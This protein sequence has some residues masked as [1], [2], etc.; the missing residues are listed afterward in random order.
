MLSPHI[1]KALEGLGKYRESAANTKAHGPA[2][3]VN[4]LTGKAGAF[5]EKLRYLIDYKEEHTI[6]RN[7]IERILRRNLSFEGRVEVGLPLLQEMVSGSYLPN[8]IISESVAENIQAIVNKYILLERESGVGRSRIVSLMACEI[9]HFLYPQLIHE[10]IVE[11]FYQTIHKHVTYTDTIEPEKLQAQTYIGCRRSLLEDDNETL[12]YALVFKRLPELHSMSDDI[13]AIRAIAPRFAQA[14]KLIEEEIQDPLGWRLSTRLK[15]HAVY[16]SVIQEIVRKYGK[17]SKDIFENSEQLTQQVEDMMTERYGKQ[18]QQA[19]K[20]GTR[21]V[22]YVLI[23]KIVLGLAL[24]LPYERI[25]LGSTD[26]FALGVNVIF[27]PL[28]L[29]AMAKT[30]RKPS[31]QNTARIISG[32]QNVLRDDNI[33]TL[34][35]KPQKLGLARIVTFTILYTVLFAVSFGIILWVLNQLNFNIVS[36]ILFLLFLT[37]VSYLGLRIRRKAQKWN[38]M[39]DDESVLGLLWNFFTIPIVRTGRWLNARFS[40]VNVFVFLLDFVIETPF[41]LLLGTFDSFVSF[42]KEKREDMY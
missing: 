20:S 27:H 34:Y 26:Y 40:T 31:E 7:A 16:F 23:T 8:D 32:V 24:E 18:Y 19:S 42:L 36:I 10:L 17:S 2:I 15:N 11:A 12:F 41:K 33:D 14:T 21:A 25:V 3:S 37:L 1:E 28:L 9:E 38:V 29:L 39:R 13:E 30:V 6:R 35:I 4:K 22:I 5:Y